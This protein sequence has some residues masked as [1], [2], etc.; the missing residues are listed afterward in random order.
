MVSVVDSVGVGESENYVSLI[1][2]RFIH[3]CPRP[4]TGDVK[5]R[6]LSFMINVSW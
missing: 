2:K 5:L 4:R 6:I 3:T 1:P